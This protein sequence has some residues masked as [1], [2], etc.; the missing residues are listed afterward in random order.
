MK[1]ILIVLFLLTCACTAHRTRLDCQGRLSR[2]NAPA[3][4]SSSTRTPA[5]GT[6]EP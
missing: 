3:P 1:S 5:G 4:I 2:I 6:L